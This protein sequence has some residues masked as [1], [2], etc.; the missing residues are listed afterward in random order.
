[1]NLD[2]WQDCAHGWNTY[3]YSKSCSE[4]MAADIAAAAGGK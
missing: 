1:M 3:S 4:R 2:P